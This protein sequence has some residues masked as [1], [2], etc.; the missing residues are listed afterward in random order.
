MSWRRPLRRQVSGKR[1]GISRRRRSF[2]TYFT[3]PP[4]TFSFS[5]KP[6]LTETAQEEAIYR[7]NQNILQA[8]P[9][10][11]EKELIVGWYASNHVLNKNYIPPSWKG[12][13]Q[14]SLNFYNGVLAQLSELSCCD[15]Q[16]LNF[17]HH[18]NVGLGGAF[19]SFYRLD[20]TEVD[21]PATICDPATS[22]TY[23]PHSMPNSLVTHNRF[24]GWAGS[25]VDQPALLAKYI[26][27]S[28]NAAGDGF[29]N[30][31]YQETRATPDQGGRI[32]GSRL[33]FQGASLEGNLALTD[34]IRA[35]AAA[36]RA[37]RADR[38]CR[39]CAAPGVAAFTHWSN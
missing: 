3:T 1:D 24:W 29:S 23:R 7:L 25:A 11:A 6:G 38:L 18:K 36:E 10:V 2:S 20:A 17:D 33:R 32:R 30:A 21:V 16:G 37:C 31:P 5:N 13:S 19:G 4:G 8:G 22:G 27:Q 26:L 14:T 15:G 35:V 39:W 28:P 12:Q 34:A 9:T